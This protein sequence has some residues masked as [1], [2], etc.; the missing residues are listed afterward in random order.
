V[1]GQPANNL[2]AVASPLASWMAV[3][4]G[5]PHMRAGSN[6]RRTYAGNLVDDPESLVR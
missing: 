1:G 2:P 3:R 6:I 4:P 5:T